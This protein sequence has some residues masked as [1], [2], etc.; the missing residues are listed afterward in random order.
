[1]DNAFTHLN[2]HKRWRLNIAV[3]NKGTYVASLTMLS[4]LL[5]FAYR[6]GAVW[7]KVMEA[8][9]NVN[10]HSECWSMKKAHKKSISIG[11]A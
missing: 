10:M 6:M 3:Y 2:N 11:N 4:F 9:D 5:Q 7:R 1:M 8:M